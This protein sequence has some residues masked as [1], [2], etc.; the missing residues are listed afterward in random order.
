MSGKRRGPAPGRTLDVA[1][2]IR[3]MGMSDTKASVTLGYAPNQV[4]QERA[5]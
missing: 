4:A 1:P 2:L 3:W 5:A